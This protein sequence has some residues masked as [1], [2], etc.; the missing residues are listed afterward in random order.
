[1][2]ISLIVFSCK[3]SGKQVSPKIEIYLTQNRIDSYQGIQ[4]NENHIDSFNLHYLENRFDFKIIR[5]DTLNSDLIFAGAFKA[6][7][8]DLQNEPILSNKEIKSF[9]F[10]N[11]TLVLNT[12]GM[13]KLS[14]IG[15][16]G[17]GRQFVLV[18]NDHIEL[19]GY[20]Y[21][22]IYSTWCSTF[23]Y[24]YMPNQDWSKLELKHGKN[25]ENVNLQPILNN[26]NDYENK[27]D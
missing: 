14:Q 13:K 18:I 9:D 8:S 11:G 22:T 3:Q 26:L 24:P 15:L 27:S 10:S 16:D 1:M 21:P 7:E 2:F 23:H 5:Y 12:L 4:V 20:F 6:K 17:Y 19:F 25:S